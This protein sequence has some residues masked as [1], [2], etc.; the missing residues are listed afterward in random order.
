MAQCS[1]SKMSQVSPPFPTQ[2]PDHL[3]APCQKKYTSVQVQK[4]SITKFFRI[5]NSTLAIRFCLKLKHKNKNLAVQV[6]LVSGQIRLRHPYQGHASK[7]TVACKVAYWNS[8]Q[9]TPSSML[10]KDSV[11]SV[12]SVPLD[13]YIRDLLQQA[14]TATWKNFKRTQKTIYET[15]CEQI[16]D[17]W[18]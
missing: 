12:R 17:H 11:A 15:S 6:P 18:L 14:I 5:L 3:K 2:A 9:A 7:D 1:K 10:R 13:H 8:W 16:D 4:W